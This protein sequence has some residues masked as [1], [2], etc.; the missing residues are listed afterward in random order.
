MED[1]NPTGKKHPLPAT[2]CP[3]FGTRD[4]IIWATNGLLSPP[5]SVL[6]PTAYTA[7]LLDH[8]YSMP[9]ILNDQLMLL[10]LSLYSNL[11]ST[12]TASHSDL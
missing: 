12:F 11:G 9:I 3:T 10:A 6:L 4:E 1:Q 7:S 8:L 5:F 2:P